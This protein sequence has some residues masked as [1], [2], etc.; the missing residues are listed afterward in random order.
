QTKRAALATAYGV[1]GFTL[2]HAVYSG[3]APHWLAHLPAV[4]V[5]RQ[6]LVQNYLVGSDR[7]GRE[8]IKRREADP[9]GLPPG[10]S[11]LTSP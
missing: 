4:D 5:L 6:V 11:R 1:D 9:D 10:R 7:R 2:L 8:V 3:D